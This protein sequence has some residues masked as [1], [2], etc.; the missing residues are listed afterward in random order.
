MNVLSVLFQ[1]YPYTKHELIPKPPLPRLLKNELCNL[2]EKT[3]LQ[4]LIP[5]CRWVFYKVYMIKR[6]KEYASFRP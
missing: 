4:D 1:P 6:K 3:H 2:T 5:S